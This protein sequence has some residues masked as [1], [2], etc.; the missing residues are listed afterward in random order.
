MKNKCPIKQNAMLYKYTIL[1]KMKSNYKNKCM[2]D[3]FKTNELTILFKWKLILIFAA[4]FF[5]WGIQRSQAQFLKKLKKTVKEIVATPAEH[6]AGS[7]ENQEPVTVHKGSRPGSG[8]LKTD[9]NQAT[10]NDLASHGITQIAALQVDYIHQYIFRDLTNIDL[11]PDVLASQTPVI[12]TIPIGRFTKEESLSELGEGSDK[13]EVTIYLNEKAGQTLSA[14]ALKQLKNLPEKHN[15]YDYPWGEEIVRSAKKQADDYVKKGTGP[16]GLY[17]SIVFKSKS[18]GPYLVIG[19]LMI[20]RDKSRFLAQVSPDMA[21]AKNGKYCLL[22]MDGK[23]RDLPTG[24]DLIAND[25]CTTGAV[26][27]PSAA[28]LLNEALHLTDEQKSAAMQTKGTQLMQ[29]A[30]NKGNVYFLKGKTLENVL[31]SDG[32]LDQTGGNFFATTQEKDSGFDKGIYLNGKKIDGHFVKRG[33]GWAN[34]E[35]SSW[36]ILIDDILQVEGDQLLFSDGTHIY[37]ARDAH[38]LFIQGK[39]YMVWYTYNHQYSNQLRV[40]KKQL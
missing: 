16:N 33:S 31:I 21:Y 32:W 12:A 3:P 22:G 23:T 8:F 36:A 24:G 37:E 4:L 26:I 2:A 19:D 40:F 6:N 17:S 20:S 38:P 25:G 34:A 15:K 14:A 5:S 9:P 13:D 1:P 11:N 27:I 28:I 39:Y 18:Y 29:S 30:P 35:G 10:F 7:S